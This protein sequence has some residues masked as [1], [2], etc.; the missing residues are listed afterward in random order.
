MKKLALILLAFAVL[1]APVL[2]QAAPKTYTVL[3]AGGAEESKIHIWLSPDGRDYVI[4]SIVELEV[5]GEI[6]VH[7]EGMTNELV[8]SAAMVAGFA[9]KVGGGGERV[10]GAKEISVPVTRSEE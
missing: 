2:A 3:L 6:C 1:Q 10:A 5:G 4:D 8:C 7:P 9:V